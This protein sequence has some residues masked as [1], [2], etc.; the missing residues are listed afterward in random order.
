MELIWVRGTRHT[1]PNSGLDGVY[2]TPTLD[3]SFAEFKKIIRK[4]EI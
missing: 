4:L 2:F 3:E 1:G